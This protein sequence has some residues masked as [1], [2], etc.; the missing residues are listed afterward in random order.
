MGRCPK[1]L[2]QSMSSVLE[3]IRDHG[4]KPPKKRGASAASAAFPPSL[5]SMSFSSRG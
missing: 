1:A 3:S 5:N 2:K 4:L